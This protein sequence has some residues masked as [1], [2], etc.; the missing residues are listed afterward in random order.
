[1]SAPPSYASLLRRHPTFRRIWLGDVVSLTG[2]WFTTISLLSMMLELTGKGEAVAAVLIARFLPALLFGPVAGV[3]ADRVDRRFVLVACDVL[4]A[5]VV[6]GFLA[7]RAKGDVPLAYLLCFLQSSVAAFFDPAEQAAVASV[8]ERDDI[9][10]ANALQGVTWSA[11]LALGALAGGVV[12]QALGRDAAFLLNAATYLVSALCMAS[13]A[14]P[15]LA[16]RPSG[17]LTLRSASGWDEVAEG[18]RFFAR[19]PGVRRA[20]FAKAGWGLSGG[21]AILLYSVFG[22]RVFPSAKGAASVIGL[23][24]AARGVGALLGPTVARRVADD[25]ERSLDRFI[26]LGFVALAVAYA[27]FGSAPWLWL[28]ALGIV[29]AHMGASTLWSFS[30]SLLNLR[31]PDR[32]RGRAFAV[33]LAAQTVTMAASTYA[34][35]YALDH[36]GASPRAL[37]GVL[38]AVMLVPAIGWAVTPKHLGET[39]PE[40]PG[41]APK[42]EIAE[43]G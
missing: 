42:P 14:I 15:A 7:V 4:R 33:D 24:Y 30:T 40:A 31:V 17:R 12:S 29:L 2:D 43:P 8:V 1:M 18:V 6:L 26:G 22:E 5:A 38:A 3:V 37:M 41:M 11:M 39:G 21:G 13:A 34:T 19:E 28:A 16:K 9:V 35:G 25:S 32:L 36:L 10:A 27:V 20:L 23:L